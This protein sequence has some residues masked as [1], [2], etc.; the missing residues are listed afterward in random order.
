MAGGAGGAIHS[1]RHRSLDGEINLVPFIDLLSMCI[2]FLLMTAIWIEVGSI[3]LHQLFGSEGMD[4]SHPV[5]VEIQMKAA[6]DYRISLE[7]AGKVVQA[8]ELKTDDKMTAQ[9]RVS[10]FMALVQGWL[11]KN[12]SDVQVSARVIPGTDVKYGEMVSV[13]DILRGYGVSALAV[14]PV[15]N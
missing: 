5:E 6:G 3:Q 9:A 8:M 1:G 4:N 7:Q 12:A 14:V 10:Q 15:R 2:C 11:L 13:L